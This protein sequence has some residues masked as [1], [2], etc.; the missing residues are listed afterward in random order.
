M[1][2]VPSSL[3]R[4]VHLE[5][6]HI[7]GPGDAPVT[8]VA[9]HDYTSQHSRAVFP[10][11]Q[12][13][14]EDL[15]DKYVYVVRHFPQSERAQLAAELA[16][17]AEAHGKFWEMHDFLNSIDTLEVYTEEELIETAAR[18]IGLDPGILKQAVEQNTYTQRVREDYESG[19]ASGV[20][21]VPTFFVNGVRYDGPW[22]LDSLEKTLK[23]PGTTRLR[24]LVEG[25][26]LL[27]ASG[28]ILLL[29]A[30]IVA[31]LW[32]NSPWRD[33]YFDLWHTELAI[34][35]GNYELQESLLHWINDGLLVLFFLVVGLEIKREILAG[36]LSRPRQ[37]ILPLAGA[38]GGMV[39]P[40][41][42]YTALNYNGTGQDGWGIPVA[43]DIAFM[44]GILALLGSRVPTS[45]KIFFTALA[46]GDD[47]GAVVI[48]ALFYTASIN[49][50]ALAVGGGILGV[51]I[52]LNRTH[53]YRLW[54][55]GLLGIGLWLA[56]FLSGLHATIAG[57]L[58][59]MTIPATIP[60]RMTAF[61]AQVNAL[62]NT[63]ETKD[64][65]T[66]EERAWLSGQRQA[67]ARELE[68]IAE[69]IES[70][71]QRLEHLLHPWTTYFVIPLFALANAGVTIPGGFSDLLFSRVSLGIIAG[72]MIGKTVGIS[73]M[74]WIVVKIG[75]ADLPENVQWKQ[76]F[77]VSMLAGIG[78]TMSLFIASIAAGDDQ[79][80]TEAKIGILVASAL[81]GLIGAS[82][83][84]L[85][86]G[87]TREDTETGIEP[88][89]RR[90]G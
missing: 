52:L 89:A 33:A 48:I 62:L 16:E 86:S 70:P 40:A 30:T 18:S 57:V 12:G 73:L 15:G 9:Y 51:L 76:L 55:Y 26:I 42:I 45:L 87:E 10:L 1:S 37:A 63:V 28:G 67:V 79:T 75:L 65:E 20:N 5:R 82:V 60:V 85:V 35:L 27:E 78:F 54:L 46:I 17:A 13:L 32:A 74:S 11:L 88:K 38:V 61:L 50:T 22:E 77:S 90:L 39:M 49:W 83:T 56:I 81:A 19:I 66:E 2:D 14:R 44:L 25:F 29:I 71:L 24:L 58:L 53:V 41:I 68:V 59:G 6:D 47:L 23:Q 21:G 64:R 7:D 69:R 84:F 31:L 80:L 34:T 4:E 8:L 72:L 36:E 3:H 43:T